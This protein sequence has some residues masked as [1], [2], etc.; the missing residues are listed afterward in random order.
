MSDPV[1]YAIRDFDKLLHRD[2][3]RGKGRARWYKEPTELT[4]TMDDLLEAFDEEGPAAL[5]IWILTVKL[6]C[7]QHRPGVLMRSNGQ[8]VTATRLRR[9]S[10]LPA[11]CQPLIERVWEWARNYGLLQPLTDSASGLPAERAPS[12]GVEEREK[13]PDKEERETRAAPANAYLEA[14]RL[15]EHAWPDCR[16]RDGVRLPG[17]VSPSAGDIARANAY[18]ALPYDRA[19]RLEHARAFLSDSWVRGQGPTVR[20]FLST[21]ERWIARAEEKG[22]SRRA[23]AARAAELGAPD[24][25]SGAQA[26]SKEEPSAPP[27]ELLGKLRGVFETAE[28]DSDR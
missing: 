3:T 21:A 1:I 7:R 13:R 14:Y 2:V 22:R 9:A 28:E 18:Y 26:D 15:L 20:L 5:G 6:A 16:F 27:S 4:G 12:A 11:T 8:P 10:S 23:E 25:V 24:W 17:I 19:E